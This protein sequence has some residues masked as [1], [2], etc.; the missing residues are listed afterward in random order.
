MK[1]LTTFRIN[2]ILTSLCK[3]NKKPLHKLIRQLMEDGPHR[4]WSDI[5]TLHLKAIEFFCLEHGFTQ[6]GQDLIKITGFDMLL[7]LPESHAFRIA[8]NIVEKASESFVIE[9][10]SSLE[11]SGGLGRLGE[12]ESALV[13][14][15][16]E[17]AIEL[18]KE[19]VGLQIYRM[20]LVRE[21]HLDPED[22]HPLAVAAMTNSKLLGKA[23]K[24]VFDEYHH[25]R[26]IRHEDG[27]LEHLV[28]YG[29]AH[30]VQLAL[31]CN[32]NID[33]PTSTGQSLLDIAP[34]EEVRALLSNR[35]GKP[36][37][38]A[39]YLLRQAILS[40]KNGSVDHDVM[41]Q[42][43]N[44]EKPLLRYSYYETTHPTVSNIEWDL[45]HAAAKYHSLPAFT[46]FIPYLK[47]ECGDKELVKMLDVLLGV[48]TMARTTRDAE[49]AKE[50]ISVLEMLEANNIRLSDPWKWETDEYRMTAGFNSKVGR[51][52]NLACFNP[53]G[54]SEYPDEYLVKIAMLMW[55]IGGIYGLAEGA[56]EMMLLGI[57]HQKK[58]LLEACL[59][60]FDYDFSVLDT[61]KTT[62]CWTVV[63]NELG[64]EVETRGL[65]SFAVQNGANLNHQT[66]DGLTALHAAYRY[67][68]SMD[69]S[70][71]KLLI[72][73]GADRNILD[74][75]G[76]KA[77]DMPKAYNGPL[78]ASLNWP[79][80][81][82]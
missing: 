43:F 19:N 27:Y 60:A 9:A 55:K 21:A 82:G 33:A 67:G 45:L 57:N 41:K 76:R 71:V 4:C 2:R 44:A 8:V 40:I 47:N 70:P 13:L 28:L 81:R 7:S 14:E 54:D 11:Q 51:I 30:Y 64:K 74:R 25:L 20:A 75:F 18:G 78:P 22:S 49:S 37:V 65:L 68:D 72:E 46:Y 77:K 12:A 79:R 58:C 39:V 10:Y 35:G 80:F 73:A 52:L 56:R 38:Q 15:A 32:A 23:Y 24:E 31:A 29:D 48:D 62:A 6:E 61:D 50:I 3:N 1:R 59:D 34:N 5:E 16:A 53:E 17:K 42:I 66:A 26:Y 63:G 69:F 36:T